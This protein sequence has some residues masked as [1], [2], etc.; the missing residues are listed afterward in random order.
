MLPIIVGKQ[1]NS[2]ELDIIVVFYFRYFPISNAKSF[3]R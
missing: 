3:F 1:P 2:N